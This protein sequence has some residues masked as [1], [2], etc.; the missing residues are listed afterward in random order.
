MAVSPA[1]KAAFAILLQVE[2]AGAFV[3][4]LLHGGRLDALHERDRA[5][6]AEIVLGVLR[7]RGSLDAAIEHAAR[8]PAAKLD[9]EVR[10]ALR[11][12]LYQQRYL[13]RIPSHAAVSESVELIK[14]G[15][16]R[17]AAGLICSFPRP[18]MLA[19][20]LPCP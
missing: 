20:S 14:R 10:T 11:M 6:A 16:K 19:V 12:G 13:E 3:D 18:L 1:R 17:S 9:L 15:P 8:R 5:L 7:R 2:Q 4:E